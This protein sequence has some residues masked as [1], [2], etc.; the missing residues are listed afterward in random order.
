MASYLDTLRQRGKIGAAA[1]RYLRSEAGEAIC[2]EV[3]NLGLEEIAVVPAAP[4]EAAVLTFHRMECSGSKAVVLA[5]MLE[6]KGALVVGAI[7]KS[8]DVS[9]GRDKYDLV[10]GMTTETWMQIIRDKGASLS[11][12][13]NGNEFAT[14]LTSLSNFATV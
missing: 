14:E 7:D 11:F 2:A 10:G 13:A 3:L 1:S 12:T 8:S 5:S 6:G 9:E 4:H